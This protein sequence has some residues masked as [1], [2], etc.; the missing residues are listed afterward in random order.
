MKER[1]LK[2]RINTVGYSEQI[3]C[4]NGLRFRKSIHRLVFSHFN[5]HL[6]QG[7]VID[8]IDNDKLNNFN[9]NLQQISSREN[10]SKD[11]TNNSSKFTGVS[12]NKKLKKYQ[13]R[14]KTKGYLK[15][16]GYYKTEEEASEIYQAAIKE[17]GL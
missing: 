2:D 5:S 10:N 16:L 6:I 12:F 14:I 17:I 3:L 7:M 9:E 13:S 8:H 15:H 1:I 4:K 11:K